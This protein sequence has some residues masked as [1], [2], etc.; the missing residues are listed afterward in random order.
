MHLRTLPDG[1]KVY[2]LVIVDGMSRVLLSHEVCSSKGARDAILILLRVFARWGLPEEIISDNAGAFISLLYQFFLARLQVKVSHTNPGHPWEN[3]HAEA[4]IGTLRAYFYP[5]IQHQ[6]SVTGVQRVYIEKTDYYNHRVHWAFRHDE[7]KTPL[8]KLQSAKGRPLPEDF[9][10][11]MLAT[12]KRFTR[13][14]DGQ[15]RISWKRYRLY[16]RVELKKEKVEIQEFF[17]SLVIT[18]QSGA[19]ATY[20]CTHE[21]SQVASISNAP[22]FHDHPEIKNSPQLE[23]FD[24]SQFQL[25]YVS[26]R[27]PN[28]KHPR[29]NAIQLLMEGLG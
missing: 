5:H 21:R 24:L 11:S 15:G 17:D 1:Q 29:G 25:R 6:R 19:V 13:T 20:A 14:I 27:P 18:Y 8:G 28:R 10:L 9:E 2:S 26:R 12:G 4:L 16:I 23:L 3:A 7:V 22:V